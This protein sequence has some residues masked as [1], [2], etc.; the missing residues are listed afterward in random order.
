MTGRPKLSVSTGSRSWNGRPLGLASK[1][2]L[3][4]AR[5]PA[6]DASEPRIARSFSSSFPQVIHSS[7]EV[8]Y[9]LR[10]AQPETGIP[11]EALTAEESK[12][13]SSSND[14]FDHFAAALSAIEAKRARARQYRASMIDPLQDADYWFKEYK[15]AADELEAD[16]EMLRRSLDYLGTGIEDCDAM[17]EPAR[18]V[19]TAEPHEITPAPLTL[20]QHAAL[21]LSGWTP[22]RT[23]ERVHAIESLV[24]ATPAPS[25]RDLRS[26]A[27]RMSRDEHRTS[28]LSGWASGSTANRLKRHRS[29]DLAAD[30][31]PLWN[32]G[33]SAKH[34]S[35]EEY[36]AT[37]LSGWAYENTAKRVKRD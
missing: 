37:A 35:S 21:S 17:I 1:N 19:L 29:Q 7:I 12:S 33:G 26:T 32:L 11:T 31:F 14:L 8:Q 23:S 2:L 16:T 18:H 9:H 3:G 20:D 24:H 15:S 10:V 25:G 30:P 28:A 36:A 5:T 22:R 4:T 27:K 13:Q 6:P 34:V